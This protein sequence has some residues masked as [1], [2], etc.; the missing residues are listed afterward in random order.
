MAMIAARGT[1]FDP[2]QLTRFQQHFDQVLGLHP[3]SD[4]NLRGALGGA[5]HLF[6]KGPVK[7]FEDQRRRQLT[8]W[9]AFERFVDG[10]PAEWDLAE[11]R[12][13]TEPPA[14]VKQ[15][16]QILDGVLRAF[17]LLSEEVGR[18]RRYRAFEG[19]GPEP[20]RLSRESS[21]NN[22]G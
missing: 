20:Q 14:I 22:T 18:G 21:P 11:L 4:L 6:G 5:M 13:A 17:R 9:P 10:D 16:Q 1:P 8:E 19:A 2:D 15:R 12:G 3:E 7:D